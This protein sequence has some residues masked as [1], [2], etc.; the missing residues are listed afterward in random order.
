MEQQSISIAKAGVMCSLP[1]RAS[2][3]AAANP[4]SGHYDK[5]KTVS[6]NLKISSPML[7]RFDLIFI[8]LDKPDELHDDLLSEHV[9]ALRAG[10]GLNQLTQS[11]RSYTPCSSNDV[12]SLRLIFSD[13]Y[14]S[15][16]QLTA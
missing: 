14:S 15:F 12:N 11:S 5:S 9:M 3:L 7:S 6:E 13:M 8:I 10:L 16:V 4:V 1:T 2:I